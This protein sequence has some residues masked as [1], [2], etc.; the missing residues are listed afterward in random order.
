MDSATV[1]DAAFGITDSATL[2][3]LVI[4]PWPVPRTIILKVTKVLASGAYLAVLN[5]GMERKMIR[6]NL[7]K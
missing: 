3:Q 7:I 4:L 5:A 6:M 1:G 2:N